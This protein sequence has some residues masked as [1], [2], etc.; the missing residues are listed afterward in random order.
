ML[1]RGTRFCLMGMFLLILSAAAAAGT[2]ELTDTSGSYNLAPYTWLYEDA[3]GPLSADD[4]I[5]RG[6]LREFT[7]NRTETINRGYS[8]SSWWFGFSLKN[9]SAVHSRWYLELSFPTMDYFELYRVTSGRATLVAREGDTFPFFHRP[10]QFNNFVIPL[11]IP[12]GTKSDFLIRIKST[13][14]IIVP[15][16]VWSQDSFTVHSNEQSSALWFYYGIMAVMVLY[17]LFLFITIRDASYLYYVFYVFCTTLSNMSFNGI[18]YQVLWPDSPWFNSI[19][20]VLM[21]NLALIG[22][23]QFTRKFLSTREFAP[24]YDRVILAFIMLIVPFIAAIPFVPLSFSIIS[25]NT[26]VL[27]TTMLAVAACIISIKKG[28]RPALFYIVAMFSV[29]LGICLISL[30]NFGMLPDIFITRYGFQVGTTVEVVL[31]SF[32]LGYRFNLMR[33]ENQK[34]QLLSK[35]IEIARTIYRSILPAGIPEVRGMRIE[36]LA[37]P[38]DLIGGDFYEMYSGRE[39]TLGLFLADVSGHGVPASMGA[40]MLKVAFAGNLHLS[41][42]PAELMKGIERTMTGRMGDQFFTATYTFIDTEKKIL[43][44]ANAGHF[45]TLYLGKNAADITALRPS[46]RAIGPFLNESFEMDELS[47][48]TG[49]RVVFYTD[50]VIECR[51]DGGDV[52]GEARLSAMLLDLRGRRPADVKDEVLAALYRWIA[53]DTRLDDDCTLI[54]VDITG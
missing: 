26:L 4:I 15:L 16:T 53:P 27:L 6:V 8:D 46:G 32:A 9:S 5:K 24:S 29:F 30:R 17:N 10:I 14:E 45:S 47:I 51:N 37:L 42:S 54:I 33:A 49:D 3:E 44:H 28:Y 18:A 48:G 34:L 21:G 22:F 1:K 36:A 12:Q 2:L 13:S 38:M 23:L 35:E 43:R 41:E 31:L 7:I 25:L 20:I 52:F 39:G 11:S 40:A 50:G 19:S